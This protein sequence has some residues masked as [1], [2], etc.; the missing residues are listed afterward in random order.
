MAELNERK[1]K[2]IFRSMDAETERET[3]P[4]EIESMAQQ[5]LAVQSMFDAQTRERFPG[6]CVYC[7]RE[8]CICSSEPWGSDE[9]ELCTCYSGYGNRWCGQCN[10]Y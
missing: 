2:N 3:P 8:N 10:P 9:C 5:A 7:G 1:I 6:L 4:E